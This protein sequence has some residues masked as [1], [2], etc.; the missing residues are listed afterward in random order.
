MLS[1][2]ALI[3]SRAVTI[4]VDIKKTESK[5]CVDDFFILRKV[6]GMSIESSRLTIIAIDGD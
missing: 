3:P 6:C 5:V 4:L 1:K 2:G